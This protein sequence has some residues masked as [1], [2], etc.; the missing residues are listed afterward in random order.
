M[1]PPQANPR[2]DFHYTVAANVADANKRNSL[3]GEGPLLVDTAHW[4]SAVLGHVLTGA[5]NNRVNVS[6]RL[7]NYVVEAS[8]VYNDDVKG[9]CPSFT[10]RT[11]FLSAY[12]AAAEAAGLEFSAVAGT[13]LELA[14]FQAR[15]QFQATACA[16]P[17]AARQVALAQV[18]PPPPAGPRNAFPFPPLWRALTI[19]LFV[20]TSDA[21]LEVWTQLR[22][23][24]SHCFATNDFV[25]PAFTS[26]LAAL[27]LLGGPNF[28]A[29]PADLQAPVLVPPFRETCRPSELDL[30]ISAGACVLELVRRSRPNEAARFQQLFESNWR[31]FKRLNELWP[32]PM[33]GAEAVRRTRLLATRI[34]NS[35]AELVETSVN[36]VDLALIDALPSL[37]TAALRQASNDERTNAIL[38]GLAAA[39]AHHKEAPATT[40][41][42]EAWGSFISTPLYQNL[43]GV[44][45]PH[46]PQ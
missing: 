1:P 21:D 7:V 29:L 13:T 40:A 44:L 12:F 31:G 9:L 24:F 39:L 42:N 10:L 5:P 16:L 37:N 14:A 38:P 43:L 2:C 28:P 11:E 3:V 18:L 19:D 46:A 27:E 6:M 26:K 45:E 36:V 17:L 15:V 41:P 25:T 22:L 4:F 20:S 33:G 23:C 8:L 35:R 30:F 34:P 32:H